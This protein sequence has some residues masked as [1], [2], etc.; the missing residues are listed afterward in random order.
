[1][2]RGFSFFYRRGQLSAEIRGRQVGEA[3]GGRLNP[4]EG[5]AEDVCIFVKAYPSNLLRERKIGPAGPTYLDLVDY[6]P[7]L[8]WLMKHQS[9]PLIVSSKSGMAYLGERLSNPMTFIPQHHCNRERLH[10]PIRHVQ[11]VGYVGVDHAVT[12]CRDSV[13]AAVEK[14][15]LRMLWCTDFR[16][17]QDVVDAYQQIDIQFTWR[18]GMPEKLEWLKNPMKI[19]N[20]GSFG[21]PTVTKPEPSFE[22]ECF[23]RYLSA[24][25]IPEA[26]EKIRML[27]SNAVL[28]DSMAASAKALSESY[29]LDQILPLYRRLADE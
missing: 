8:N 11:T 27:Q 14:M 12:E 13:T 21:I 10:R 6:S 23:G 18:D 5:F 4:T 9:L 3:L 1:M 26:L 7:A 19:I 28:Y 16:H 24:P 20:A 15:G 17:R 29:H 25:T 2:A 22:H